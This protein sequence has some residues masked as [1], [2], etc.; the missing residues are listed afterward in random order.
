[1]LPHYPSGKEC[2]PRPPGMIRNRNKLGDRVSSTSNLSATDTPTKGD[3]A[4]YPPVVQNHIPI[5]KFDAMK[6]SEK[7]ENIAL[8]TLVEG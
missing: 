4:S 5:H 8:P 1:V 2:F 7:F 3:P 6:I